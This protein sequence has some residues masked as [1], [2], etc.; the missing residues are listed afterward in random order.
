MGLE[1]SGASIN[2]ANASIV[3][4]VASGDVETSLKPVDTDTTDNPLINRVCSD[5][6]IYYS[7]EA[8]NKSVNED[9]ESG[10]YQASAYSSPQHQQNGKDGP[11][12]LPPL[13]PSLASRIISSFNKPIQ[14]ETE[15]IKQLDSLKDYL[16]T[17]PLGQKVKQRGMD[18]ASSDGG[19]S[20]S[21]GELS[22]DTFASPNANNNQ[23]TDSIQ[24][25]Q[26]IFD[27]TGHQTSSG[28]GLLVQAVALEN[29]SLN[30]SGNSREGST[31]V[32]ELLVKHDERTASFIDTKY[33]DQ[34]SRA[35]TLTN[36]KAQVTETSKTTTGQ[37]TAATTSMLAFK[38]TAY[39][40]IKRLFGCL[41]NINAIKDPNVHR[42]VVEFIYTKWERLTRLKDDL[43][44]ADLSQTILPL[45][46]FSAWLFQCIYQLPPGYLSGKLI[47]YKTLCR[48]AIKSA[49]SVTG[50][51]SSTGTLTLISDT[52]D[53]VN[54]DFMDLFYLTLHHGLRSD[55]KSTVNCIIQTCNTR[56]WH[57]MMPSSTLLVRDFIDACTSLDSAGPKLEAAS[58]LGCL[59]AYPDYFGDLKV[60]VATPVSSSPKKPSSDESTL[61]GDELNIEQLNKEDLKTLIVH[62]LATFS[63][64]PSNVNSRCVILCS[65][66][67]FI[68]DEIYNQKWNA[69]RLNDAIKR[70]FRDLESK[71]VSFLSFT[72]YSIT[73]TT[74]YHNF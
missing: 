16:N 57:C 19:T 42:K 59:I 25:G 4:E 60:F 10:S 26:L 41:D 73:F 28:G 31:G 34:A 3:E 38:Q 5:K 48:M 40:L 62:S 32:S 50:E 70:I 30:S 65:L 44:L 74:L 17:T 11:P 12:P 23:D 71:E 21:G 49:L 33:L 7:S 6:S 2:L 47:A 29:G 56:F 52:F 66:T 1:S 37:V 14:V 13:P 9:E 68:F 39:A 58:I 51:S 67:C 20:L 24:S 43:K 72:S 53:H 54:E 8:V 46:Y 45:S 36:I 27:Q 55:D 69:K 15:E 35:S 22:G 63:D 64:D 61:P 18:T